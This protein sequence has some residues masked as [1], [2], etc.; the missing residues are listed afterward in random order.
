MDMGTT[1]KPDILT[2]INALYETSKI[3]DSRIS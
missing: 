3:I 2:F 1:N